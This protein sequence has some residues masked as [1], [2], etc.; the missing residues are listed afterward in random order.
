MGGSVYSLEIFDI[1]NMASSAG[2]LGR[3]IRGILRESLGFCIR[4]IFMPGVHPWYLERE[5]GFFIKGS[6]HYNS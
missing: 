5:P 3:C 1:F 6:L 2:G 4:G